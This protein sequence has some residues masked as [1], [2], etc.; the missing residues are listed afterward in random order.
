MWD[1]SDA[2]EDDGDEVADA[3]FVV[4]VGFGFEAVGD[5][6]ADGHAAVAHKASEAGQRRTLHFV[7][8]D[9]PAL[10]IEFLDAAVKVGVG[11]GQ[12]Q[13]AALRTV[14]AD[15]RDG[16]AAHHVIAAY[17][18]DEFLVGVHDIGFGPEWIPAGMLAECFFEIEVGHFIAAGII[19][20]HTVE[21]K[22]F[23][24]YHGSAER[25]FGL[26]SARCADAHHGE[27]AFFGPYLAGLEVDVGQGVEFVDYNVDIVGADTVAEAHYGFALVGASDGV[28]FAGRYFESPG[29]EERCHHVDARRIAYE[30]NAVGELRG[31]QMQVEYAAV[32]VDY[33]FGWRD[34]LV[35]HSWV[36]YSCYVVG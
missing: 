26:Q 28:E 29:V 21:A 14:E 6:G 2:V 5:D 12:T 30:D 11:K 15:G 22:R 17:H 3:L 8:G 32:G 18:V 25:Q 7:V 19:V 35:F 23:F 10:V 13:L 24:G 27:T 16:V 4:G 20:E 36:F 34:N 9:F 33:E 31:E 1:V